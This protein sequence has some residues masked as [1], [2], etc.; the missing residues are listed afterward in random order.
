MAAFNSALLFVP[1]GA[2]PEYT[3]L[4]SMNIIAHPIG[5]GFPRQLPS[6]KIEVLIWLEA[7]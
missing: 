6:T 1:C 3:L 5:P 4:S 2:E 7:A